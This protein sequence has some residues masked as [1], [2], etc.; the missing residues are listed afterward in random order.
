MILYHGSMRK[1]DRFSISKSLVNG[2]VENLVEGLGV[3]MTS[4]YDLASTYG[5]TIYTI[6]VNNNSISDFTNINYIK[7]LLNNIEL[8][9]GIVLD[10]YFNVDDMILDVKDGFISTTLLYKEICDQL[11]SSEAF[12]FDFQDRITYEDDCIF[13]EIE[14]SFF[15]HINDIFKYY[16]K[17]YNKDIYICINNPELLKIKCVA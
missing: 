10:D 9:V 3:Y 8:E 12:Y 5:D 6:E 11:D 17:S 13:K 1:F 4:D 15:H 2:S 7:R 16:D 14:K